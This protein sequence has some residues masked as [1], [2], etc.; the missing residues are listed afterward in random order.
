MVPLLMRLPSLPMV[1][2]LLSG[3]LLGLGASLWLGGIPATTDRSSASPIDIGF[4]RS[5]S[6][7]HQQ[8]IGMAQLV[9]DGRPTPLA[10]LARRIA[11]S[12]LLELGEMRGWLR[13][14]GAPWQVQTVNMAWMLAAPEPPD[15]ALRR[16]LLDCERSPTG[17]PGL[18][19][20]AQ[21][22]QLR[23]LDGPERDALFL[24]LMLAH[25]EGGLPMARF[26]ARYAGLKVVRDMAELIV[27][28]Q[29]RELTRLRQ[30][31]AAMGRT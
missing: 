13:L 8:A 18:A 26:A 12:Q 7:H 2:S 15:A 21:M 14:W 31:L 24:R 5:M 25:H 29:S 28:E 11:Y 20:M 27:L 23:E 9:L 10:P 22:Q 3:T 4:A 16:Y 19:T 1:L 6:L 17:M 30:T